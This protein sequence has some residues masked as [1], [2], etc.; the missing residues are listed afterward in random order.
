MATT[1]LISGAG[2]A[3]C[4]TAYW[5][6]AHGFTPTVV[7]QHP[8]LRDGGQT[9]DLRG[10]GRE[11]VDRMGLLPE[12]RALSVDQRGIAWVDAGGRRRAQLPVEAFGGR[13]IV[14]DDE[15]LRGDLGRVLYDG[16][17]DGVEYVFGDTV[18]AL[19]PS[20]EGVRVE[21]AHGAPRRFDLVVGA[22]GLSS[23]VRRLTFGPHVGVRELDLVSSW[24]TV[25]AEVDLGGWFLLHNAPGGRV[26]SL[27][28][29]RLPTEQK[30]SLCVR[31]AEP[32][33]R[34][35]PQ[36][37]IEFLTRHVTGMGWETPRVVTAMRDADDL[38]VH[39]MAQVRLP[40]W[41]RDRV[42]LVGDAGYC[43][44]PLTGLGTSL[45]L[46]GAYVLAGE[47]A[48]AGSR[49]VD[50]ALAAYERVLRPYV[51]PAQDIPMGTRGYAPH[52]RLAIGASW[53][54]MR[55]ATRWPMRLV[56]ERVLARP[57][58]IDLPDYAPTPG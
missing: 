57:E 47:L 11:V 31:T 1:I 34:D 14:S 39:R 9:I 45:A 40:S 42:V 35:D 7:E 5:L 58:A 53:L 24:F 2:I 10:A 54:S 41:S 52:G 15:I 25:P 20:D 30:A 22:D 48:R 18:T 8:V 17:V 28:P 49:H 13:G 51:T 36:A 3:G 16:A 23:V 27:R 6:R 38:Y 43:P 56:W 50:D 32:L 44:T 26:V 55:H 37:Q 46:V 29:G 19:H 21:F 4:A 12:A 33:P